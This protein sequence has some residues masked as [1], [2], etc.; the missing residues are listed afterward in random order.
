M[1]GRRAVGLKYVDADGNLQS[2][3]GTLLE[4]GLSV[5]RLGTT[6]GMGT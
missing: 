5:E 1:D 2:Y 3:A 4:D 6:G